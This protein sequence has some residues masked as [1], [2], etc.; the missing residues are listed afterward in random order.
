M[1]IHH[2]NC[3]TMCPLAGSLFYYPS[4]AELAERRLV[5]QCLLIETEADGLVLVDTGFGVRDVRHPESRIDRMFRTLNGVR[6]R[7]RET[8]MRQVERLGFQ[9]SDVRHIVLTHLDF[10]HAGGI[11]DFEHAKVHLLDTELR[12]AKEGRNGAIAARRYSLSQWDHDVHWRTYAAVGERWFGFESVRKLDGLPP[13]ILLVPLIGH[14]RGHCGVAI[15][16]GSGWLLHAG[17]S[18]FFHG[19]MDLKHPHCTSG[20]RFYQWL[21]EMNGDARM[22]NQERLRTLLREHDDEVELF[23]SHDAAD[24]IRFAHRSPYGT[25][26]DEQRRFASR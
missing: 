23:C 22:L 19:E 17:D 25:V 8:A 2:L 5:C 26:A 4:D 6:L 12:C 14:T 16:T 3:G 18:Y 21:M 7:E 15:D 11:D 24:F 13:E 9:A 20:L 1:R 10:D